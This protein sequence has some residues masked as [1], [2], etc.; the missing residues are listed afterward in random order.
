MRGRAKRATAADRARAVRD[1]EWHALSA[2]ERAAWYGFL[3]THAE[4]VKT[5]DA[6]LLAA[7]RLPLSA[8]DVLVQLSLA[9]DGS[10]RMSELADHV[11]LSRSGL[12]RLVE[13]LEREGLVARCRADD[14]SRGVLASLTERGWETVAEAAP[15]HLAGIRERFVERL[16]AGQ[17]RQ[18]AAAWRR[19]APD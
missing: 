19:L 8:F 15:T 3:R 11:L 6:E 16:G 17:A 2:E 13:R 14:D 18:L 1:R 9:A 7:H 5:L 12:T 10:M 4:L